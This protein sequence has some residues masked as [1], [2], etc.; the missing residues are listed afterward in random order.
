MLHLKGC[1]QGDMTDTIWQRAIED[2]RGALQRRHLATTLATQD[3][4]QRYNRS[5]IGAFWLSINMLVLVGAL[6]F[7]FGTLF[8]TPMQEFLPFLTAGMIVWGF[9]LSCLTEGCT[10]F[11]AS[12]GIILQVRMPLTTHILRTV[13]RNL[14]ILAHNILIL[15]LVMLAVGASFHWTTILAVPGIILLSLNLLW[16][17]MVLAIV[18]TRFRDMTQIIQNFLQVSFYLTPIV[19]MPKALPTGAPSRLLELNPFL[20]L[21]AIVRDPLLGNP[22]SGRS[23][24]FCLGLL[25]I[26]TIAAAGMFGAFRRRIAYWL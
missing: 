1:R 17:V 6:G 25:F 9:I 24:I 26:G 14:F 23:W 11:I 5:R 4:K 20:H 18:C 8:R 13:E 15:P 10:A 19:W 12:E 3:I 22:L 7:V 2:F 21:I 16:M